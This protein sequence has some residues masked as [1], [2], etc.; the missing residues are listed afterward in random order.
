[1]AGPF[2]PPETHQF[3]DEVEKQLICAGQI[4]VRYVLLSFQLWILLWLKLP[5]EM[6]LHSM[7]SHF[8]WSVAKR[9]HLLWDG[10][11]V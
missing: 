6:P 4:C 5:M 11:G 1:M 9:H 2:A 3:I 7:S 10:G 8:L